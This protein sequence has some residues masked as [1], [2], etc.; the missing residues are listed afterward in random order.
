MKP[1]RPGAIATAVRVAM[2]ARERPKALEERSI[3]ALG[4]A[5]NPLPPEP[6]RELGLP[7]PQTVPPASVSR[8]PRQI[9]RRTHNPRPRTVT[10]DQA[11][12]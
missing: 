10:P 2:G 7:G 9:P 6:R 12:V 5:L 3:V 1:T 4:P 11:A 8:N